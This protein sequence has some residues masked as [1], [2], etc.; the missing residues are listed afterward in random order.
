MRGAWIF[1][2]VE[3]TRVSYWTVDLGA[4]CVC[5][6]T[7]LLQTAGLIPPPSIT[8]CSSAVVLPI[9]A[10]YPVRI[11]LQ[12]DED[13]SLT[14]DEVHLDMIRK[15][16]A[17]AESLIHGRASGLDAAVCTYGEHIAIAFLRILIHK[18]YDFGV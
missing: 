13:G 18:A 10:F 7:A 3:A 11:T 2:L 17:A 6:A 4:F 16:S 9:S 1:R 12:V 5:I 8:V 14:W 15:W